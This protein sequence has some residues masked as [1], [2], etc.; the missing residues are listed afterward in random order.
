LYNSVIFV[1]VTRS[2]D[3]GDRVFVNGTNYIVKSVKLM[4]TELER[5]D[6]FVFLIPNWQLCSQYEITNVRRSSPNQVM[7]QLFCNYTTTTEQIKALQEGMAAFIKKNPQDYLDHDVIMFDLQKDN[8]LVI[9]VCVKHVS[10]WQDGAKRWRRHDA[11]TRELRLL[12]VNNRILL[13]RP[14]QPVTAADANSIVRS[15][16]VTRSQA[17]PFS[18]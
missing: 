18:L 8:M 13:V 15:L 4:I 6:G 2:Y 7:F 9:N 3:I 1:F 10:N 5:W 11:I 16:D 12:L 14:L 17:Q